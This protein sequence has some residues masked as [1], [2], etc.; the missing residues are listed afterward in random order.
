MQW[1]H[2]LFS[3]ERPVLLLALLLLVLS[4]FIGS[5]TILPIPSDYSIVVTWLQLALFISMGCWQAD[6]RESR[7]RPLVRNGIDGR[8]FFTALIA[9]MIFILLTIT[10]LI[11][12]HNEILVALASGAGF[13]LPYLVTEQWQQLKTLPEERF[14]PWQLP[15]KEETRIATIG[16]NSQVIRFRIATSY[17]DPNDITVSVTQPSRSRLGKAFQEALE[18]PAAKKIE[19]SDVQKQEYYWEFFRENPR[20][21]GRRYLDP[22]KTL[23][24]NAIRE[25]T[26]ITA[27][28]IKV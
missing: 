28:R 10:Y 24:D 26:T 21:G 17:F 18:Q 27:K 7:L 14:E 13:L 12:R 1:R 6:A 19:L 16:L 15:K 2:I 20:V 22:E 11:S 23:I 8:L 3:H 25:N 9:V 5:L 4:L